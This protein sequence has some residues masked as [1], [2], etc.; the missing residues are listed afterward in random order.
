MKS[1]AELLTT[2]AID[3]LEEF[4]DNAASTL[5]LTIPSGGRIQLGLGIKFIVALSL[6]GSSS[7]IRISQLNN[8]LKAGSDT[9]LHV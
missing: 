7:L 5:T 9:N 2:V 3:A 1:P 6:A 8:L 4:F